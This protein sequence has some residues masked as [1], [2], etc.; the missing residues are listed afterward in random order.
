MHRIAWY[1]LV[2][3]AGAVATETRRVAAN[4]CETARRVAAGK[5]T[6]AVS[7][8]WHTTTFDQREYY[9]LNS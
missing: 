9:H 5:G 3:V 4:D 6:T 7:K 8:A 1:K 2:A